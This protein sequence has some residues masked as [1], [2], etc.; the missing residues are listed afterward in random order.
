MDR[1]SLLRSVLAAPFVAGAGPAL[2]AQPGDEPV[3]SIAFVTDT[4]IQPE[5]NAAEACRRCFR[6]IAGQPYDF[7]IHG[8]DHVF[9][10]MEV[11]LAR[12]T[13][14]MDLYIATER[15]I[16]HKVHH[17][18]GNHDC[19]GIFTDSGVAIESP[20]Y[21]KRYFTER[22]GPTYYSFEHKGVHF[23][24]LDSIGITPDRSYQGYVDA[25]QLDWLRA[26]L[27][28]LPVGTPVIVSLHIPLVTALACYQPPDWADTPHNWTYVVNGREVLRILRGHN[29]LAVLQGHGH[30]DEHII[31]NGVP[32][33]T[34]GSLCGA[35]WKGHFLGTG[36]G[37][38]HVDVYA[39]RVETV[40]NGFGF[41]EAARH[42]TE[43]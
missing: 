19:F 37:Y 21:G 30:V 15:D 31:L 3:F 17:V 38:L 24:V 18:I 23:V 2:A 12:A 42:D 10:A 43:I 11:G 33:V 28:A 1:R 9:D 27:A 32:F 5:R 6:Q 36:H 22:F 13:E 16:G 29:I 7:V 34:G 35:D 26:D 40:Y 39:D 20:H 4:H 41:E 14:L 25:T 8:G